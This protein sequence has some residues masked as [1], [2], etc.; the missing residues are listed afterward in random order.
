MQVL[1]RPSP[2]KRVRQQLYIVL[3]LDILG[4]KIRIVISLDNSI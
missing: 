2:D 4:V 1:G 3:W